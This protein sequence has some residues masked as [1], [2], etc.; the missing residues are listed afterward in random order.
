MRVTSKELGNR[1]WLGLR[2]VNLAAYWL[3]GLGFLAAGLLVAAMGRK[4]SVECARGL[5]AAARC[6]LE[7]HSLTGD[8]RVEGNLGG[9]TIQDTTTWGFI[10]MREVLVTINSREIPLGLV[11]ADGDAKDDLAL[12]LTSLAAGA[13]L[14]VTY[15]EDTRPHLWLLGLAVAA[16]GAII[17]LSIEYISI[18]I[19][20]DERHVI[21]RSRAR[22]R[23]R[24]ELIPIGQIAEIRPEPFTL[25]RTTSFNVVFRLRNGRRVSV[26]RTPLFT[27]ASAAETAALL[28]RA[29]RG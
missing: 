13:G 22:W 1:T 24:R 7:S 21:I 6:L 3:F 27:E 28:E 8:A 9:A 26:A 11:A 25:R 12:R 14:D 20:R 19:D 4:T 29:M 2:P 16:G 15:R 10:A 5:D 23:R 17:L 18:L